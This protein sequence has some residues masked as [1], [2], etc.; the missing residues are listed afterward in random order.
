MKYKI[1]FPTTSEG[2]LLIICHI[3]L[4]SVYVISPVICLC[5]LSYVR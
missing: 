2:F 1:L 5:Q 3:L 4:H